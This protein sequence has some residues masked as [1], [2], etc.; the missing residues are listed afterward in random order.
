MR[1]ER[2]QVELRLVAHA[3]SVELRG[4]QSVRTTFKLPPRCIDALSLLAGQLGIKQ[5]SIVDHLV[6]DVQTLHALAQ[7][8]VQ[9]QDAD[10]HRVAKTYVIS[11]RTLE[12]LEQVS[13]RFQAPRDALI[14]SSIER[15]IPLL[16]EEKRKHEQRKQLRDRLQRLLLD[17][18]ELLKKADEVLEDDDPVAGHVAH[19]VRMVESG[20]AEVE[21]IIEKG[22]RLEDF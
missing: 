3:S 4:R 18:Q 14:E 16:R 13:K 8:A 1:D 6:D 17:S 11:R 7:E 15:I 2:E 5:K 12:S 21:Q 9:R 10:G 22:K 20:C 19:M